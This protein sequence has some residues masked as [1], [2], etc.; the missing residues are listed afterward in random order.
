MILEEGHGKI[1]TNILSHLRQSLAQ[2]HPKQWFRRWHVGAPVMLS[3]VLK[4]D[5]KHLDQNRWDIQ[6][7]DFGI[8]FSGNLLNSEQSMQTKMLFKDVIF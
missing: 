3:I 8:N 6:Y 5:D 7:V 2:M 4:A 1:K